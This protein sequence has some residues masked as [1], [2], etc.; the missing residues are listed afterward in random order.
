V[1]RITAVLALVLSCTPARAPSPGATCLGKKW[2]P[3]ITDKNAPRTTVVFELDDRSPKSWSPED[4]CLLVDDQAMLTN[5][6]RNVVLPRL[7]DAV[8]WRGTLSPGKHTLEVR[9]R[10]TTP[11]REPRDIASSHV[12]EISGETTI[13]ARIQD[14]LPPN[15]LAVHWYT[16]KGVPF[17]AMKI[18][19]EPVPVAVASST[20]SPALP[21]TWYT[22]PGDGDAGAD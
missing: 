4:L 9:Y 11:G 17:I 13:E 5:E 15:D 3:G 20:P 18:A 8:T 21:P 6:H 12:F 19:A 14:D 16:A 10:T 1:R 7:R 22:A 2:Y